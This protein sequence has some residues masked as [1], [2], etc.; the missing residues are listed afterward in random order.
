MESS[1]ANQDTALEQ[2]TELERPPREIKWRIWAL[3]PIILLVA[4]VSIFASTGGSLIDLVGTNPPPADEFD[5]RRVEFKPGEIRVRVTN[6]QRDELTIASVTVDAAILNF[7]LDGPRTLGRLGSS[8]VIIPIFWVEEDPYIVGITSS[9]GI[10][11]AVEIA[12]AVESE[13]ATGRS[14]LGYAIIGFLVGI[15]PV[16]FGVA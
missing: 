4:A 14:F 12:A 15:V 5:I 9:T 2:D 7:E 1:S 13:G 8:T 6:P 16:A 3:V 11:T 10:E